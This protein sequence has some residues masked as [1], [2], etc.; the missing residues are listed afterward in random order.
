[1]D[2]W[3]IIQGDTY[4]YIYEGFFR[5]KKNKME[6]MSHALHVPKDIWFII[7]G[8]CLS[9]N[10]AETLASLLCACK[11]IRIFVL[12]YLEK[13]SKYI[14]GRA[15]SFTFTSFIRFKDQWI[16]SIELKKKGFLIQD[17]KEENKE[18]YL[19]EI[20]NDILSIII[21]Y[22]TPFCDA[23]TT[24]SL[25]RTSKPIRAITLG[26]LE[27][28]EKNIVEKTK[29]NVM[30]KFDTIIFDWMYPDYGQSG[31]LYFGQLQ[32]DKLKVLA[33]V[34]N[35]YRRGQSCY[36]CHTGD[37]T[38]CFCCKFR[39]YDD[40][41]YDIQGALQAMSKE[42][43]DNRFDERRFQSDSTNDWKTEVY[44]FFKNNI[45][46][47]NLVMWTSDGNVEVFRSCS[48]TMMDHYLDIGKLSKYLGFDRN[49]YPFLERPYIVR[50]LTDEIM[51]KYNKKKRK[52]SQDITREDEDENI[53]GDSECEDEND[54]D[55]EL[56]D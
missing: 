1:M 29:E 34:Y 31:I 10:D 19:P 5:G 8:F 30:C 11:T 44:Q 51:R 35:V 27:K 32:K 55:K 17:T 41:W 28:N 50:Y 4:I 43:K 38:K 39:F 40:R 42:L 56:V 46:T 18:K 47:R 53:K 52:I 16:L 6:K 54:S 7:V 12:S 48:N 14:I 25:L 49:I 21:E 24:Y 3:N 20:P 13:N 2:K 22:C 45:M 9:F 26:V 33:G 37:K 15:Y 23:I 36:H